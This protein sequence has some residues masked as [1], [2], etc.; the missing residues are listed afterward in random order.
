MNAD[1][2]AWGGAKYRDQ[3][4]PKEKHPLG[5]KIEDLTSIASALLEEIKSLQPSHTV[6][7]RGG[8]DFYDEV[9]KFEVNL[10]KR[11]L[12][13]TGGHQTKAAELLNIKITTLNSKIKRYNIEG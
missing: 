2:E 8:I 4:G 5:E 3:T 10:I 7:V 12:D 11:A 13:R 1:Q 6:D 9:K